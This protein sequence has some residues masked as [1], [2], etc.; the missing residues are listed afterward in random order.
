[1][2]AVDFGAHQ[3]HDIIQSRHSGL[4]PESSQINNGAL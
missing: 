1:V 3:A 4:D 2:G